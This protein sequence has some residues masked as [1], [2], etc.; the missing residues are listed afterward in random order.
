MTHSSTSILP[1]DRGSCLSGISISR[2]LVPVVVL[3]FVLPAV[4]TAD[5]V[6]AGVNKDVRLVL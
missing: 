2:E 6:W 4:Q 3:A 5:T 1:G